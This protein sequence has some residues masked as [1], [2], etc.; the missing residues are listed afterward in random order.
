MASM[1]DLFMQGRGLAAKEVVDQQAAQDAARAAEQEFRAKE[2]GILKTQQEVEQSQALFPSKLRVGE[3]QAGQEEESLLRLQEEP[4]EFR[5]SERQA[6]MLEN[7]AK[8][9]ENILD[10][11]GPAPA[12]QAMK[13]RG[14]YPPE[15]TLTKVISEGVTF[16]AVTYP[17]LQQPIILR[18]SDIKKKREL[19]VDVA[20]TRVRGAEDRKTV[21]AKTAGGLAVEKL[22]QERPLTPKAPKVPEIRAVEKDMATAAV[23]RLLAGEVDDPTDLEEGGAL[24]A[25]AQSLQA[26]TMGYAR[27]IAAKAGRTYI[28]KADIDKGSLAAI[29]L[30]PEPKEKELG[31]FESVAKKLFGTEL[32]APDIK[33]LTNVIGLNKLPTAVQQQVV[34]VP[35]G[36]MIT[37][38]EYQYMVDPK[39]MTVKQRAISK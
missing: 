33:K 13:D 38:G 28:T 35:P 21:A 7:N 22:R 11:A 1:F 25:D 31:F 30:R 18:Q 19:E 20:G 9:I 36:T 12:L 4:P 27:E 14:Y 10:V 17:G 5:E 34:K 3:A 2:L 23:N 6:K 16:D 15:A 32:K 39:T 24:Y 8:Y 37:V 29:A 26:D